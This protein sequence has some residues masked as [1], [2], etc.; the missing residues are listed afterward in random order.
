MVEG[1]FHLLRGFCSLGGP[2]APEMLCIQPLL[3]PWARQQCPCC[4]WGREGPAAPS[5]GIPPLCILR[6]LRDHCCPLTLCSG[7]KNSSHGICPAHR[8]LLDAWRPPSYKSN[9]SDTRETCLPPQALAADRTGF[10]N[11]ICLGTSS[12][13]MGSFWL[14][15][16]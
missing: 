9:I 6:L 13:K 7:N 2:M 11:I 5:P 1:S 12:G 4:S 10:P 14:C 3:S 16:H 15:D 8:S